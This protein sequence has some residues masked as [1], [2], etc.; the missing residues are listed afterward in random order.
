MSS[1]TEI[2]A[3]I[4]ALREKPLPRD[5]S[6]A[7]HRALT[8]Y[9]PYRS[10]LLRHPT[11]A[12]ELTDPET[13]ELTSPAFGPRDVGEAESDLTT[14]STGE[15]LGERVVVA[16]RLL[17]GDGRPVRHQLIEVWQANA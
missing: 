14:M 8:G 10:S 11:K 12:L 15:P 16:G 17:D 4:A 6:W 1:Q 5:P 3:E 9:A 13:I 7:E 2:S